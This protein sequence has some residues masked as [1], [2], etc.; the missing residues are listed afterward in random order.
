MHGGRRFC[1]YSIITHTA[2]FSVSNTA[3]PLCA[4]ISPLQSVSPAASSSSWIP[5]QSSSS[6]I[7]HQSSSSWIPY[8]SYSSWI[9]HLSSS[10][11]QRPY[12]PGIHCCSV[13]HADERGG[14]CTGPDREHGEGG[15][16]FSLLPAIVNHDQAA[17]LDRTFRILFP[18][19]S[20][21]FPILVA[22][23]ERTS[24]SV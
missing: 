1:S 8:Q 4:A 19:L 23:H 15:F 12:D 9:P 2:V 3:A 14:D 17:G 5:H 20:L 24:Y 10:L 6:W 13:C 7:P 11:C 16:Q 22:G 18:F 21:L